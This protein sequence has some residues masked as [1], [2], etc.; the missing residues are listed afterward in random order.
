M[1]CE[2]VASTTK[3]I[4]AETS[5]ISEQILG[6]LVQMTIIL[7]RNSPG[8]LLGLEK[9]EYITVSQQA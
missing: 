1:I 6:L 5:R 7:L 8:L 2:P 3:K 4:T 9:T